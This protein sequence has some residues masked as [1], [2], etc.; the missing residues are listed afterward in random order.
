LLGIIRATVKKTY[1]E[2]VNEVVN[3]QDLAQKAPGEP[4]EHLSPSVN[5]QDRRRQ[6]QLEKES[7]PNTLL[8]PVR[9]S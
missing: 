9:S 2:V 8:A 1:H 4:K 6:L 7:K 3:L 5:R